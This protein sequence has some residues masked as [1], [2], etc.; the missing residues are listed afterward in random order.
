MERESPA[1]QEPSI[2]TSVRPKTIYQSSQT[3]GGGTPSHRRET[4]NI[5]GRYAFAESNIRG[6]NQR[7]ILSRAHSSQFGL[8][9]KVE[10]VCFKPNSANRVSAVR[11][12]LYIHD[13]V[14]TADESRQHITDMSKNAEIGACNNP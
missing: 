10:K 6:V 9:N 4:V 8:A 3:R 14:P 12:R 1:V 5:L 13:C 11:T 2:W 7:Q